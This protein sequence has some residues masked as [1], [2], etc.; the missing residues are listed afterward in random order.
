M[1]KFSYKKEDGTIIDIIPTSDEVGAAPKNVTLTDAAAADTLPATTSS[2]ITAI[3]QTIRNVLKSFVAFKGTK[4]QANGLATLDASGKLTAAQL[5]DHADDVLEYANLAAFPAT[6][7]SGKLYLAQDSKKVYHW[8]GTAYSEI[9]LGNAGSAN[10]LATARTIAASGDVTGTAT[11]FNGTANITIPTTLATVATAGTAGESANKTL[12]FGGTFIVL[13][14]TIDAKGRVTS[15]SARTM[16][17]PA[18]P[19]TVSGNAGTAT[20]LATARSINVNSAATATEG[21]VTGTATNFDGSSNITI[22]AKIPAATTTAAGALSA[23]DK[24]KLDGISA[25]ATGRTYYASTATAIGTAA[26]VIT[27]LAADYVP[28]AGDVLNLYVQYGNNVTTPTL[29]INST[30]YALQFRDVNLTGSANY[31]IPAKQTISV[32]YNGTNFQFTIN[33]DWGDNDTLTQLHL[34]NNFYQAGAAVTKYHIAMEGVD[35][36]M[37]EICTG[38]TNAT[39]KT[40]STQT[41]KPGGTIIWYSGS[42]TKAANAYFT[43]DGQIYWY[44]SSANVAYTFNGF[45]HC[46]SYRTLYLKGKMLNGGFVLDNTST[47]SWYTTEL[48]TSEDGFVYIKLGAINSN[49]ATVFLLLAEHPA[50]E[51]R[52]GKIRYYS[53]IKLSLSGSNLTIA[54]D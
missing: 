16:T 25:N 38:D 32:V 37:Y 52:N 30:S 39:T 41:F 28:A 33:P 22:A 4:G 7:A 45:S 13:Q 11:S 19:T 21:G 18:A 27:G 34:G 26:K 6:G 48:P 40:A 36:K 17:M 35:G 2:A 53:P 43:S 10:Q 46:T 44:Y 47:T 51:Y 31:S 54:E 9:F 50:V 23:A 8:T 15:Q 3:L 20:K 5:P 12:T 24:T 14:Q 49:T 29:N 1:A 42:S